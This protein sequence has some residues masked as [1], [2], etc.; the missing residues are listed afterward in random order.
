M[1]LQAILIS[2]LITIT[3]TLV[4]SE[5][6]GLSSGLNN[7][8]E[9]QGNFNNRRLES[10]EYSVLVYGG[11]SAG[12]AAAITASNNGTFPV[13]LVEPLPV[14]GGM[15]SAGG[16]FLNDQ[17]DSSYNSFFVS[18]VARE[19]MDRVNLH[20]SSKTDVIL[21]DMW[22]AQE[23][24]DEM[25]AA[26]SS[27]TIMTGCD[28]ISITRSN[29]KKN[30][31]EKLS[32]HNNEKSEVSNPSL[33]SVTLDCGSRGIVEILAT[34]FIDASYSGDLLVESGVP[35]TYGR[36]ANTTY[37][38]GLAGAIDF[39]D[40]EDDFKVNS[41]RA[42]DSNG[43]LLPN[44]DKNPLPEPGKGDNR[45]MAFQHRACVTKD[46][47][48]LIPFPM[49][50][51]YN[52]SDYALL[53]ELLDE[54][55]DKKG[56]KKEKNTG[57]DDVSRVDAI[58]KSK[59][60]DINAPTLSTF[61]SLIPFSEAVAAAGRHKFQI[62]CGGWPVNS[63]AITIND[64]YVGKNSTP[65]SRHLI[66]ALHTRYLLGAFYY[67]ANDPAVPNATRADASQYGLCGDEWIDSIPPHWPVQL[68][69]RE[70][71]RLV[72][73]NVLTQKTLVQNRIKSDGIAVG[74]WYLDKHVVTR[75]SNSGWAKNSGHFRA[76]TS[77]EKKGDEWCNQRADQC[78]NVNN[79]FY[80]IPLNALLPRRNDLTNLIVPTGLAASSVAYTSTRI[81][82]M[83]MST[84]SA[85][86]VV[87]RLAS[88][89][90]I[91]V[92]DVDVK[93][94]QEILQGLGQRIHGPP[95]K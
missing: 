52:R 39:D 41:T 84:G 29:S 31:S 1:C 47:S 21:P 19:L 22:V 75:I 46:T 69:I 34:V 65:A 95:E 26:R 45:M 16:L 68:Y 55:V 9:K 61:A 30:T 67:L 18:G 73:D 60:N 32:N 28:L 48:L 71:A 44:V 62:C 58:N 40:N 5:K 91:A 42:V 66:D 24:I 59:Q 17:L 82:S 76:S 10:V 53:Q 23:A 37:L 86:G 20:Y 25:L 72:N 36:E 85:A 93:E 6:S 13:V 79:E 2:I 33:A 80:D 64:G 63:D 77:W 15:L 92:Q 56:N 43:N 51:G 50:L 88:E 8:K 11:S 27:I 3:N 70:G 89:K 7:V 81:E 35:Y 87:A 94:V 4:L 14:V 38:E 83:F 49:P 90:G 12:V 57:I 54:S 74:A 78:R